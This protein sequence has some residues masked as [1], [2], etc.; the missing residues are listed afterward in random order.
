M[1][2]AVVKAFRQAVSRLARR[3]AWHSGLSPL[4]FRLRPRPRILMFHGVGAPGL[5]AEVFREQISFLSRH[6]SIA[7]LDEVVRS[8]GA[9]ANGKPRLALT[10]DD[11]L[12]NN[13]TVAYPVLREFNAPATFFV[14]PGLIE[15]GRWLWN[16]ECRARLGS[17]SGTE[18]HGFAD[19]LRADAETI[20]AIVSKMKYLPNAERRAVEDEL[21]HLT[22][23]FAPNEAQRRQYD[24]I[25]WEELRSLDPALIGIGGHSTSHQILPKLSGEALER[26]VAECRRLL[27]RGLG[28]PVRHFCYPDGA[29]DAAVLDCVGRHFDLA[30][31]TREGFIPSP[32]RI[33]ELPRISIADT[34]PDLAWTMLRPAG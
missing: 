20:E 10:F 25:S 17:M 11:G 15:S 34:L 21:R 12:R 29:Y 23:G 14:C 30:V 13:Y 2:V 22:P 3:A 4:L 33:L 1:G 7:P 32:P 9:A 31:T 26:E 16:H 5:P 6:F 19:A 18:R 28:R 24:M 27:E 8:G